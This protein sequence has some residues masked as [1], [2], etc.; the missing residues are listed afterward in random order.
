MVAGADETFVQPPA[1]EALP[2]FRGIGR[3]H[4]FLFFR[5]A[6][7]SAI[8]CRRLSYHEVQRQYSVRRGLLLYQQ[9]VYQPADLVDSVLAWEFHP[10]PCASADAF[11][12][13]RDGGYPSRAGISECRGIH[14]RFCRVRLPIG[15]RGFWTGAFDRG[16][17]TAAPSDENIIFKRP[18]TRRTLRTLTFPQVITQTLTSLQANA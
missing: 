9:S 6:D 16:P 14:R 13:N 1:L 12:S 2:G 3:R 4:R 18:D 17:V 10:T 11:D 5:N 15:C 7:T 8:L